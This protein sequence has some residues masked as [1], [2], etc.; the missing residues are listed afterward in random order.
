MASPDQASV[1][2]LFVSTDLR[3]G[4]Q[5]RKLVEI[6]CGIDRSRIR[7]VVACLKEPGDLAP[8]VEK[9]GIPLYSRLIRRRTDAFVILRLL[10]IIR[11]EGVRVVCTVGS[12]DKMFWGRLAGWL[13]RVDGI[14]ATLHETRK[15]DGGRVL[16]RPNRWLTPITDAFIAVAER[17]ADYLAEHEGLPRDRIR[18]IHNG[19]D[20]DVY[21]GD[22][23]A[24]ARAELDLAPDAPVAVHVAM[25]RP[26][27][28]H[29]VLLDAARSV[30]DELPDARFLLV[31]DGPERAAIEARRAE[32]DLVEHVRL[33]GQRGDVPALLASADVAVLCSRPLVETFPNSV[34]EAMA[35][36][37][38]PVCT[39]VGSI[40]EMIA[41]G[42][43]GLIVPPGDADRLAAA[44]L[45]LLSDGDAAAEM[46]ERAR[47]VV[48]ERFTTERMIRAREELFLE[49]AGRGG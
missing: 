17:A 24:A 2:V 20:P 29:D 32:L 33:L 25:L 14:V 1:T 40:R 3:V 13:A 36:R 37:R 34:L 43:T 46:G 35:S 44:L 31:G 26:E 16:E 8:Q 21:T 41:D 39:D 42:D 18:V 23:R 45:R 28:G 11:R 30:A 38:P 9:A 22:G 49:L 15:A 47:A 5:E 48:C 6:V 27:K 4:G 10:R 12:G 19:V 7:P